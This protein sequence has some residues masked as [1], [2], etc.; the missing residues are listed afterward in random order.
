MKPG[1]SPCDHARTYLARPDP[2]RAEELLAHV[3]CCAPCQAFFLEN[4]QAF[5]GILQSDGLN[6]LVAPAKNALQRLVCPPPPSPRPAPDWTT[7][8]I[9]GFAIDGPLGSTRNSRVFLTRQAS[10]DRPVALKV[11]RIRTDSSSAE[12]LRRESAILARLQHPHLV[13]IH[14]T[15]TW[16][17]GVWLALEYCK[18]GDLDERLD[19]RWPELE[20]VRL[21]REIASATEA[22]HQSGIIHRDIKPGNIL[23]T[24]AGQ[25]KLGDFGLAGSSQAPGGTGDSP[26]PGVAGTPSY[27]APEQAQ[28]RPCDT[29]TD[30]HSLG[31]VLY[32]L[33]TGVPPFQGTNAFESMMK[34]AHAMP[35]P[36]AEL[37]P[38]VSE[39]INSVCMKCLRKDPDQRYQSARE[40][41]QD[42]DRFLAGMPVRARPLTPW[43]TFWRWVWTKP[44]QAAAAGL[45]LA[46]LVI[47]SVCFASLSF[48]ALRERA[49]A[50]AQSLR[51]ETYG[52]LAESHRR[53]AEARAYVSQVQRADFEW[54]HGSAKTALDLLKGCRF[55]H[56]GWEHDFLTTRIR[57][58]RI[59]LGRSGGGEIRDIALAPDGQTLA[60]ATQ[61]GF[62][63]LWS[64]RSGA[65]EGNLQSGD[66]PLRGVCYS[67]NGDLL[68]VSG[69]DRTVRVWDTRARAWLKTIDTF[70]GQARAYNRFGEDIR[71]DAA[72]GRLFAEYQAGRVGVWNPR[73]GELL[74]LLEQ[75][76]E[77]EVRS[78]CL[79]PDQSLVAAGSRWIAVWETAT[80]KLVRQIPEGNSNAFALAFSPDGKRLVSGQENN[81]IHLW[82]IASG[83][84][85]LTLEGHEDSVQDLAFSPDGAVLA[86]AGDDH[87]VRLWDPVTGSP[88]REF[89]GHFDTVRGLAFSA[90][91]KRLFSGGWD[92]N[93]R[94]WDLE[95][96]DSPLVIRPAGL[97]RVAKFSPD[98]TRIL[99]G[100]LS[101]ERMPSADFRVTLWDAAKGRPL[102]TLPG[103]FDRVQAITC[104]PG[105]GWFASGGPDAV[106]RVWSLP[107]G[108]SPRELR[109]HGGLIQGLCHAPD[110]KTLYSACNDGMVGMWD[111]VS[112]SLLRMFRA[113]DGPVIGLAA[114]SEGRFLATG[115]KDSTIRLWDLRDLSPAVTLRGHSGQ[116][117]T[118]AFSADGQTLASGDD[119]SLIL[120]WEIRTGRVRRHLTGHTDGVTRVE[121]S[122]DQA[123]LVSSSY[124]KT[125]RLWDPSDGSELL[126]LVHP[127]A[128]RSA[129][130]SPDGTSLVSACD[131]GLV[132]VWKTSE[133]LE[134]SLLEPHDLDLVEGGFFGDPVHVMARDAAGSRVFWNIQTGTLVQ[135][136]ELAADPGEAVA[137]SPTSPDGR[138][139]LR[140]D[141]TR[142]AILVDAELERMNREKTLRKLERWFGPK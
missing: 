73:T 67:A 92:R 1:G 8:A 96:Q 26:A 77:G 52:K 108:S 93:L 90:D 75:P 37:N 48:W 139:L 42:L 50:V 66:T 9:P 141:G 3:E 103:H 70:P 19:K 57:E 120:L 114:D 124:D 32:Q 68:A 69:A 85:L 79:S 54:R 104:D 55:P 56:R 17:E 107:E 126:T 58:N 10:L 46:L 29:R 133:K 119:K 25:P 59:N 130:F 136:G 4:E 34:A 71:L 41:A 127:S 36:P 95:E 12:N 106:L 112:G 131:D 99:N 109:G 40:L 65:R 16:D 24:E 101:P 91:G 44:V 116:V 110:G 74:R 129:E 105:G 113:H 134:R 18:G 123:R 100:P 20:A 111:P 15:G 81:E 35:V 31:A 5:L 97:T 138:W 122:P 21:I 53:T 30:I 62:V 89:K 33:L 86:S 82:E 45:V 125:V 140:V 84:R 7:P 98:G 60:V 88:L 142:R 78:L 80:G 6:Q 87:V 102:A 132:R 43:E 28:G 64:T 118:L 47:S 76:L 137:L 27:I 14:E 2:S 49:R 39:D 51:A 94:L 135:P 11:V 72:G 128:V 13:T 115:G 23:F 121:F 63:E 117:R 61:D 22:A 83:K 38:A